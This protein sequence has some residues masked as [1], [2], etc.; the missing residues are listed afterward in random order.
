M[1]NKRRVGVRVSQRKL[2]T[3][4]MELPFRSRGGARKGAGR[5]P[6]GERAMNPHAKR[7]THKARFP[8]LVTTRL[9]NGLPSLRNLR[10]ATR[11]RAA[12]GVA[13]QLG[14]GQGFRIVHH[15]I[16][17]NHLHLIVEADDRR[18]LSRGT[19]GLLVR[20][21]RAL[22]RL[23]RRSGSVFVDRFHERS[24][25]NPR[26]VR[27]ALVYV[28][29]NLRKHKIELAGPDP[30]SSAAEFRGWR[31]GRGPSSAPLARPA[32]VSPTRP[33]G[34]RIGGDSTALLSPLLRTP[35]GP[36]LRALRAAAASPKT[37]LLETGWMR[38]GLID[39]RES[40]RG[41]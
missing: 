23:W 7:P 16:Q 33:G 38:H 35:P 28:L 34:V 3:S 4:Q 29:Q 31:S 22:N 15:S 6:K 30:Y 14:A 24:L 37:W 36:L 9:Q 32:P 13:N 1:S 11:I 40:P 39:P 27:N 41:E 20:I 26:Q 21:A 5:K 17:T 10:E 2:R 25:E 18:V 19:Q 12:F 8:V